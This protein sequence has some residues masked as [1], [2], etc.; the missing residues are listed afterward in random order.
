MFLSILQTAWQKSYR[1]I[2]KESTLSWSIPALH[3][4]QL[5]QP[6]CT[7]SHLQDRS[8]TEIGPC[9]QGLRF[10]SGLWY[11]RSCNNDS[12]HKA[13]RYECFYH[14]RALWESRNKPVKTWPAVKMPTDS[15]YRILQNTESTLNK[16]LYFSALAEANSL[17]FS[18]LSQ[19][20]LACSIHMLQS[21]AVF[22]EDSCMI[23]NKPKTQVCC[24][25][26]QNIICN[27]SYIPEKN[28]EYWQSRMWCH[29]HQ[30]SASKIGIELY[31]SFSGLASL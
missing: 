14:N 28:C 12:R 30:R 1:F 16:S 13:F 17:S 23:I 15:Y 3:T 7:L 9:I 2:M 5:W 31:W 27:R 19:P 22:S 24:C 10:P 6:F 11:L 20:T 26:Y 29:V 8:S 25:A 21:N 18:F 4:G